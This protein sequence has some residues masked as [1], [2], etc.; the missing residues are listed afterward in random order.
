MI[1]VAQLTDLHWQTPPPLRSLLGKRLLGS[2]NLYLRG[3]KDHFRR[4]VQQAAVDA[5]AALNPDVLVVTG[6]L[7]AQAL[8]DEFQLAREALTPLLQRVPTLVQ[9]GNHDVYTRGAAHDQRMRAW[10]DPWMHL[11]PSGVGVLDHPGLRIIG[12]D[13]NRPTALAASGV[14]PQAQ[15]D[16]LPAI[17]DATPSD[18]RILLALHYPIVD[19]RGALY[20]GAG[21]GLR[22][23]AALIKAMARATRTPDLIVH[24]HVHHG[25]AQH[26]HAG[27]ARIPIYNPGSSGYAYM[28]D[29]HRAAA[30]NLYEIHADG[31]VRPRRFKFTGTTFE[32]E[33]GG[34]YAS[35]R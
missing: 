11:Q 3:R 24:G 34:A 22:N 26:V 5:V 17:L 15:L 23:A 28:P 2:A 35:G 9:P 21:H 20:D 6:D 19:R 10:F 32:E 7:T 8:P 27:D 12:L 16:A 31:G 1:R 29:H 4:D 33:P 13:P 30:F 18:S 25:Y 14:V